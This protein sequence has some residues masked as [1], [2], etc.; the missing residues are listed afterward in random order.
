M[1]DTEDLSRTMRGTGSESNDGLKEIGNAVHYTIT[2]SRSKS[3]AN[4]AVHCSN[5]ET[6]ALHDGFHRR[7]ED[8]FDQSKLSASATDN[9]LMWFSP[10]FWFPS[11]S[12]E[13]VNDTIKRHTREIVSSTSTPHGS[14]PSSP[15]PYYRELSHSHESW[16]FQE[17]QIAEAEV[18]RQERGERR[19]EM[20]KREGKNTNRGLLENSEIESV[21]YS[22]KRRGSGEK[23]TKLQVYSTLSNHSI[24]QSPHAEVSRESKNYRQEVEEVIS[25]LNHEKVTEASRQY[26]ELERL[27]DVTFQHEMRALA[28]YHLYKDQKV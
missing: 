16:F 9:T 18:A 4:Q 12:E 19:E 28:E 5:D 27:R 25:L 2:S 13:E 20:K 15:N 11:A 24:D 26:A 3:Q 7:T 22:E 10:E 8:A 14:T 23:P 1:Y 17:G 21:L 6:A